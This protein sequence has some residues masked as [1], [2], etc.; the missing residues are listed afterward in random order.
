MRCRATFPALSSTRPRIDY[1]FS[2]D[3]ESSVAVATARALL[4]LPY[5]TARM[6][7]DGNDWRTDYPSRRAVEAPARATGHDCLGA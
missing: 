6:E 5:F 7:V 1:F 4:H 3:A 2:L